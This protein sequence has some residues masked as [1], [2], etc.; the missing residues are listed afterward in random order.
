MLITLNTVD[1]IIAVICGHI[2]I[3]LDRTGC[4][5]NALCRTEEPDFTITLRK[6]AGDTSLFKQKVM[7]IGVEEES[8]GILMFLRVFGSGTVP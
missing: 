4:Q 1:V 2:R 6:D 7:S 5:D 8:G 3:T